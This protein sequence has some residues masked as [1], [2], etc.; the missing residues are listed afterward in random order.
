MPNYVHGHSAT[1]LAAHQSRSA[2]SCCAYFLP[3][4]QTRPTARILDVG[5]GPGTI[6]ATLA[7][8]VPQGEV[9]GVDF[10]PEAISAASAQA[11]T[12]PNCSFQTAS[13]D[14]GLPFP[15]DSFDVVHTHQVL[16]HLADP[17]GAMKEMRRVCKKGGFIASRECD[18]ATAVAFPDLAPLNKFHVVYDK[19]LR[20]AGSEPKGGRA[21][22]FWALQAGFADDEVVY[23]SSPL[24]YSGAETARWWGELQADRFGGEELVKKLTSTG[25]GT[26]EDVESFHRAWLE[27]AEHPGAVYMMGNGEVVCWKN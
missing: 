4:L 14:T 10:S 22:R 5:C 17:V 9:T 19:Y 24:L 20:A 13:I 18:M 23:T 7:P 25:L 27:W 2:S 15:D 1:N 3:L 11:S 8:L 6:T 21:L 26:R 16:V 12:P